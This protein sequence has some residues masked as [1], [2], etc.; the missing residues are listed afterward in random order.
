MSQ[1]HLHEA[2]LLKLNCDKALFDLRWLPTLTFEETVRLTVDW[3]KEYYLSLEKDMYDFSVRQ[4]QEY[5]TLA[6]E[7]S[8]NWATGSHDD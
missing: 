2:G 8:I 4:I 3:Y 5:T 1:E 6:Q 7:R